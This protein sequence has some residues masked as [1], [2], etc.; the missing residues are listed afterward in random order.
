MAIIKQAKNIQ[1]NVAKDYFV[2]AGK[3]SEVSDKVNIEAFKKNLNLI[4]GRVVH[5]HGKDGGVVHSSYSPPDVE[6]VKSEYKLES[7][8]SH[9]QMM[10][11]AK[12]LG[13]ITFMLFMTEV[14]GYEIEAEAL[15][16]LYRELSD[17]K[18]KA[19]EIIVS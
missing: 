4:S 5:Q 14:F 10:S 19:P 7:T 15:S 11:L 16:K 8:Y 3:I 1:I 17:N 13:E 9:D 6:V 18:I 2:K 12:E